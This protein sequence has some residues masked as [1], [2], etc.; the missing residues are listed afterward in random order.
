MRKVVYDLG[1]KIRDEAVSTIAKTLIALAGVAVAILFTFVSG[2][3]E[4]GLVILLIAVIFACVLLGRWWGRRAGRQLPTVREKAFRGLLF[5]VDY[6]LEY[7]KVL[8][9]F[10]T[11][12]QCGVCGSDI[13][14]IDKGHYDHSVNYLQ[15]AAGDFV[16]SEIPYKEFKRIQ[17]EEKEKERVKREHEAKALLEALE[18]QRKE[19]EQLTAEGKRI[20]AP[21]FDPGAG[22]GQRRHSSPGSPSNAGGR[23]PVSNEFLAQEFYDSVIWDYEQ[24]LKR[25]Q[26]K[27][28]KLN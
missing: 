17:D 13:V 2:H 24:E 23:N 16:G 7:P 6:S 12:A 28:K 1:K 22:A 20:P 15:C 26:F 25:E 9:R 27:K 10:L 11:E 8:N 3:P 14:G 5:K 21:N 4:I 18:K 19:H